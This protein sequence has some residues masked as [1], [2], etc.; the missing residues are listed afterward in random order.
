MFKP[1]DRARLENAHNLWLATVRPNHAPHLVPIW[2]VFAQEKIYLCTARDSVKA[3]NI[4]HNSRV[5][6]SLEDGNDP[7]VVQ[8]D[9]KILT[10]AP[11]AVRARFQ[12]KYSWDIRRDPT[13]NCV[14]EI[15]P[16]RVVL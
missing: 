5:A 9:A 6:F 16:R 12:E 13:Y 2:F 7:L 8:G 15:T 14:I 11:S 4:S 3:R 1:Q 10:A